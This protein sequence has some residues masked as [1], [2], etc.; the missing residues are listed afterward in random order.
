[1]LPLLLSSSTWK[2]LPKASPLSTPASLLLLL[3]SQPSPRRLLCGGMSG[4]SLAFETGLLFSGLSRALPS[5][6]LG[7]FPAGGEALVRPRS[8]GLSS[9]VSASAVVPELLVTCAGSDLASLA[10]CLLWLCLV[11]KGFS[12]YAGFFFSISWVTLSCGHPGFVVV[13]IS[14]LC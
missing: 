6:E 4:A 12:G 2:A 7:R 8:S 11:A 3:L 13:V 5:R 14:A 1:M 10:Q 9:A